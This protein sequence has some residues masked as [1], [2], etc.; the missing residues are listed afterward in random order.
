MS[1]LLSLANLEVNELE[2]RQP[3]LGRKFELSGPAGTYARLEFQKLGGSLA[4]GT[5]ARASWSFKRQGMLKSH[6]N[7][8]FAGSDRD[9]ATYEPNFTGQKGALKYAG[10]QYV[11]FQST[12]FFNTEWQWLTP[13]GDGLLGYRQK[14]AGKPSAKVYLGDE[15]LHRVDLDLLLLLGFYVLLLLREDAA[16]ADS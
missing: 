4:L 13:E 12:N 8:R 16:K 10:G 15:G 9:L 2:W 11:E 3:A 7:I 1:E 5:T 14:Q 6:I